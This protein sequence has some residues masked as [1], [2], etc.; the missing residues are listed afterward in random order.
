[1]EEKNVCVIR[2]DEPAAAPEKKDMLRVAAYCRVSTDEE[3]QLGSFENQIEYYNRMITE[4]GK[5]VLAGIY[6]DEGISGCSTRSR[7]GFLSMIR[8]CEAGLI[9]LIITKSISRFARNT[10]D[11]LNYT[12]RLGEMGVGIY[13]EK[14]GINTLESSGELLLTLFSCFAQEE[15]RS[16]S[17]NTAWGIRSRFRQGISHMNVAFL[18]GYRKGED[19]RP[20]IDPPKAEAVRKAYRLF[21]EGASLNGIAAELNREGVP[22]TR[23]AP[24][25]CAAT[26]GR[27]LE[28]EKY[29][30][31]VMMQKTFTA[32]YLTRRRVKNTG[33]LNRY[34]VENDHPAIIDPE[35]WEAAREETARRREFREKHG[36]RGLDGGG[37]PFYARLFCERCGVKLERVFNRGMKRAV[38]RC[39]GCSVNVADD[40]VR[41]CFRDAFNGIVRER[42]TL[43]AGWEAAERDGTPLEKVRGRQ[44]REITGEGEIP[45]EVPELTRAV[46]REAVVSGRSIRFSFLSGEE[47]EI[48][49]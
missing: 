32:S 38:W 14:E 15:S 6:S 44:M 33:Q 18:F 31:A 12:R 43:L 49:I 10:Q 20:A 45:F 41:A 5:Y 1:M 29:K 2:A 9:D 22:G 48:Y 26:V 17:E 7:K 16:I 34:Y 35:T 24:K 40:A 3:K 19:G 21:L 36:L 39:P 28:N 46:L 13:F 27:M 4:N 30:G 37:S 25:W 11:S 42:E 23:G 8:D 47:E